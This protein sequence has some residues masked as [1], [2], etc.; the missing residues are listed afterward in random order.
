MNILKL[1]SIIA[2]ISIQLNYD[3]ANALLRL[4]S[5][6]E[7]N[8][9]NKKLNEVKKPINDNNQK[10]VLNTNNKKQKK[11]NNIKKLEK[12]IKDQNKLKNKTQKIDK[13]DNDKNTKINK[14]ISKDNKKKEND[15][16]TEI[17]KDEQKKENDLKNIKSEIN[18]K[19]EK[20]TT[21]PNSNSF[22]INYEQCTK[23]EL[24]KCLEE[25]KS[26]N[27]SGSSL[28]VENLWL[29][30]YSLLS[31]ED[32]TPVTDDFNID[33]INL[34]LKI[35]TEKAYGF[36]YSYNSNST[37]KVNN[38][39]ETIF[40]YYIDNIDSYDPNNKKEFSEKSI[41]HA[42]SII[43]QNSDSS[44][45]TKQDFEQ[46]GKDFSNKFG[47]YSLINKIIKGINIV[48]NYK[49]YNENYIDKSNKSN[50]K[51]ILWLNGTSKCFLV[52][53]VQQF[54][55]MILQSKTDDPIRKTSFAKFC[56][57]AKQ[58]VRK[59]KAGRIDFIKTLRSFVNDNKNLFD[60]PKQKEALDC[61]FAQEK[62]SY[63]GSDGLLGDIFV[64]RIF[65]E[66]QQ[67]I[68]GNQYKNTD[69][70]LNTTENFKFNNIQNLGDQF[71]SNQTGGLSV[72]Q[73]YKKCRKPIESRDYFI[74]SVYL[75]NLEESIDNYQ[76][77]S[78]YNDKGEL[79]LY[80][81]IGFQLHIPGHYVSCIKTGRSS[82]S[83]SYIDSISSG[84][85]D[86][87]TLQGIM[88]IIDKNKYKVHQAI[89]KRVP[90]YDYIKVLNKQ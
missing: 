54:H 29:Q 8:I 40:N 35:I 11:N 33:D 48:N 84:S 78:F 70:L 23:E 47:Y 6:S 72:A 51:P 68:G 27:K 44:R 76:Y 65:P 18:E 46:V 82:N 57:Y 14:D 67:F 73:D 1:F 30:V 60:T 83:W 9:N 69:L 5:K 41:K 31:S 16:K 90:P 61:L 37:N 28:I 13:N 36:N 19:L 89:Y 24:N 25:I 26:L 74:D 58:K 10:K 55:A 2:V 87:K 50:D 39:L 45:Y 34:I 21:D 43:E 42:I 79:E 62:L 22:S 53:A 17:N 86:G 52:S 15:K 4:N 32:N 20:Y 80:E 64:L 59:D 63:E 71:D 38:I 88:I 3:T 77:L 49:K 12:Y 56:D 81:L 85:K 75:R 7:D 66:L